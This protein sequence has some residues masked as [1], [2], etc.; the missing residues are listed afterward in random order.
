MGTPK[1]TGDA[2]LSFRE[3]RSSSINQN[4][5][6]S[7]A[8]QDINLTPPTGANSTTKNYDLENLFLFLINHTVYSPY[9]FLLS[10]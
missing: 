7:S 10:H 6:T 8:N 4:I 5:G 9:I 2:A 3:R 1:P